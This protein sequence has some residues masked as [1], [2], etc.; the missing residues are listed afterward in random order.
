M[1]LFNRKGYQRKLEILGY[2]MASS[3]KKNFFF[4]LENFYIK[5]D[6]SIWPH[7]KIFDLPIL[8]K[9]WGTSDLKKKNKTHATL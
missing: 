7:T 9:G 6:C 8:G 5:F 2:Q 1:T 4:N 3:D